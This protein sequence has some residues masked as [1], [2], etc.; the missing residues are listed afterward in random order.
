MF[1]DEN[2]DELTILVLGKFDIRK[3]LSQEVFM[4]RILLSNE[5]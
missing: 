4:I 3:H 2:S 1:D 5:V